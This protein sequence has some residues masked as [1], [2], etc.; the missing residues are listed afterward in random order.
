MKI[1]AIERDVEGA[2]IA[3]FAPHLRAEALAVWR[4]HQA[5][6]IRELYFRQDATSAV[7][8]LECESVADAERV[9]VALPL[10]ARGL[11]R[12]ELLPLVAYPGFERLFDPTLGERP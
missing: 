5:G 6:V 3:A 8:V 10:M 11:I 1:L 4:L 7:P 9:L 2:A 12:F